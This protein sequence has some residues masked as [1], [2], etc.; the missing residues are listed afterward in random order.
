MLPV[1]GH[2][3][4]CFFID[5][6]ISPCSLGRAASISSVAVQ[7]RSA[8]LRGLKNGKLV[9]I[10]T[11]SGGGSYFTQDLERNRRSVRPR[12][13]TRDPQAVQLP[14]FLPF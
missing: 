14:T 10:L 3:C 11:E 6:E 7:D 1:E 5:C 4:C 9:P 13:M 2:D 12:L 8:R